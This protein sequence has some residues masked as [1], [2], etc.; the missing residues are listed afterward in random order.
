MAIANLILDNMN[1][2][3]IGSWIIIVP[4][5][6]IYSKYHSCKEVFPTTTKY[7][8]QFQMHKD[9]LKPKNSNNKGFF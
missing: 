6:V 8:K 4:C 3:L 7:D 5:T 2:V 1:L 9:R